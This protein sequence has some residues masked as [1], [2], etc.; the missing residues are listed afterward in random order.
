M[1]KGRNESDETHQLVHGPDTSERSA[2]PTP[3]GH[4]S[5]PQRPSLNHQCSPILI[6][7]SGISDG[8]NG[9]THPGVLSSGRNPA[10][11]LVSLEVLSAIRHVV[12]DLTYLQHQGH[13]TENKKHVRHF[14]RARMMQLMPEYPWNSCS[15]ARYR[16]LTKQI[17]AL[18]RAKART[19]QNHK[20]VRRK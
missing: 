16:S 3:P 5:C 13:G 19:R 10:T 11:T 1:Q 8:Y 6:R 12:P 18:E 14:T 2:V 7:L 15:H 17:R 20:E 4:L 9:N